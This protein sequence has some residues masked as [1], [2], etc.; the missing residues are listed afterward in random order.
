[1]STLVSQSSWWGRERVGCFA[2][3]VFLMSRD[4]CVALPRDAKGLSAVYGLLYFF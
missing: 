2:L 4:C 1:M 3:F